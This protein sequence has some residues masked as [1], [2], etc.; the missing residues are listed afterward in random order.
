MN[1][2]VAGKRTDCEWVVAD[3]EYSGMHG[4]INMIYKLNILKSYFSEINAKYCEN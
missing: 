3:S 4:S 1:G 2:N